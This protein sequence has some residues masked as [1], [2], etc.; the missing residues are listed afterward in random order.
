LIGLEPG[1]ATIPGEKYIA[2][3]NQPVPLTERVLLIGQRKLVAGMSYGPNF[4]VH[5]KSSRPVVLIAEDQM[6]DIVWLFEYL[7]NRGCEVHIVTNEAEA[8]RQL[9][10]VARGETRY[11]F[12]L[13]DVMMAQFSVLM[14]AELDE[15]FFMSARDTGIRLCSYA[16]YTLGL[17]K[18]TLPIICYSMR[19][20]AALVA[21]L[22]RMDVPF[23]CKED[24]DS[25]LATIANI[26]QVEL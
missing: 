9:D 5:G 26:V 2:P 20:D 1:A 3:P 10:A 15:A 11:A 22:E 6:E 16:R 19:S 8:R 23:V 13:F 12:A 17:S 25:L 4:G 14:A 21:E 18:R 7:R 24:T